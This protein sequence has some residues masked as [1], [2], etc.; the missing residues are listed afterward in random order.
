MTANTH[1]GRR[2][3][4]TTFLS[5]ASRYWL[6]VFPRIR[7]E[8]RHWS[9]RAEAIPDPSLR[10]LALEAQRAKRANI[11]GCAAFAA[12]APSAH[13]RE[14]V[15]AQV[16]FQ[17]IY[18]YA[19]TLAEQPNT[20]PLANAR[21]LHQ[22]LA[23]AVGRSTAHPD[24]Y[25][26][27][28][29][30]EDGG[31]M[32]QLADACRTALETL[33]SR[34]EIDRPV[35]RLTSLI[36]GYQSLNLTEPQGG[37]RHLEEWAHTE[38]P[39]GTD[40]K[41]WETAAAAGSSLGVFA[42]ISAAARPSLTAAEATA[43]EQAYWPWVGAL[44]SLLDSLV[45][46]QQD[47]RDN[48]RSLLSYY[49]TPQET[50]ARLQALT[51]GALKAVNTLPNCHEHKLLLAAMASSYLASPQASSPT[52][53]LIARHMTETLGPIAT[54]SMTVLTARHAASRVQRPRRTKTPRS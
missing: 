50:V 52:T 12:F 38:T 11:E 39:D 25:A 6:G 34:T 13:R 16:A 28:S 29:Y 51:R 3:T 48:Q 14:V 35:A 30:R 33:P 49:D 45:D 2:A 27:C 8:S 54:A 15:R 42:L 1:P 47:V 53:S 19:D 10:R 17:T 31:Y 5:A 20:H 23:A 4:S 26:R 46:E 18:D 44:H 43:I 21:Q 22:A 24:Y 41:W 37:H 36:V 7:H 9:D 32:Q 40:L